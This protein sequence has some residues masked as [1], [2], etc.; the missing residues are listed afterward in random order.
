[1]ASLNVAGTEQGQASKPAAGIIDLYRSTAVAAADLGQRYRAGLVSAVALIVTYAFLR[2]I[3]ADRILLLAWAA[4]MVAVAV[5][6]PTLGL[7]VLAA[8]APFSE[9]LSFT[10]QLGL[11]PIVVGALTAGVGVRVAADVVRT[12]RIGMPPVPI[13][14]AMLLGLGTLASVLVAAINF[15]RPFAANAIQLWLAGIGGGIAILLVAYWVAR[16]GDRRAFYVAVASATIAGII[17]LA[18]FIWPGSFRGVVVDWL[19]RP[20]SFGYRLSGI[21]PSPNGSA[22]LIIVP[23]AILAAA[24]V[25]RSGRASRIL[26][27]SMAGVLVVALYF[28]YS[29]AALLGLFACAVIIVWRMRRA[30]GALLLAVGIVGGAIA[31]PF[32]LQYRSQYVIE[33]QVVPG[34]VLVASDLQRLDAWRAASAMW[35]DSPLFG[36]GFQSYQELHAA[37]GDVV[38]SAPHNEWIRLFA[39]GGIVV[40]LV[41]VAWAA[42]TLMALAR[43]P[44]WLGTGSFAAFA[45]WALAASFNNPTG[46]IQVGVI[47]FTVVGTGLSVAAG[48]RASLR[49]EAAA[50]ATA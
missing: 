32:Y 10:R 46:Y 40:G 22:S 9:P 4:V 41:G 42:T 29:R 36:H 2:T 1:V 26:A 31:L 44:G 7:I 18:D 6:S 37:Y 48:E 33:G 13:L 39:E 45:G 47:V 14:L 15:G 30:A 25:L 35:L 19:V 27:A 5:I 23:A 50:T 8:I 49:P 38:L 11:K 17:S 28:T 3:D 34:A 24:A 20:N 12:R 43:A 16:T 21:I